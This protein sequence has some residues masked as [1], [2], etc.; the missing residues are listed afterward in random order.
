MINSYKLTGDSYFSFVP[1]A[2][3]K[4]DERHGRDADLRHCGEGDSES[5]DGLLEQLSNNINT[6][7]SQ[8]AVE[9]NK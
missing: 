4:C 8:G 1:S 9:T 2:L 6:S 7:A 3:P 5:E